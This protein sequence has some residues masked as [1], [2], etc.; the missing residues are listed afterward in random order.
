MLDRT[1]QPILAQCFSAE[2]IKRLVTVWDATLGWNG[3]NRV[4]SFQGEGPAYG[5]TGVSFMPQSDINQPYHP[6]KTF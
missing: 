4:R 6:E 2:L 3:L 1:A 5:K